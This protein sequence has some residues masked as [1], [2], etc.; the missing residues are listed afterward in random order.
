M[1][2]RHATCSRLLLVIAE[3][4]CPFK[5]MKRFW[6]RDGV[7]VLLRSVRICQQSRNLRRMPRPESSCVQ[8]PS[9][10]LLWQ[11]ESDPGW[12]SFAC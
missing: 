10:A 11:D 3:C 9:Y 5:H 7:C 6:S 4:E 8:M 2:A 1:G 12:F